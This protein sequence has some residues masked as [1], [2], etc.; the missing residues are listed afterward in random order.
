MKLKLTAVIFLGCTLF[1]SGCKKF[2]TVQP[3]DKL[4]GNAYWKSASD[5]ESFVSDIYGQFRD[6]LQSTSFMAASGELRSGQV[7]MSPE[8]DKNYR[9]YI[10]MCGQNNLLGLVAANANWN[11]NG[12]NFGSMTQWKDLY[13]VIQSANI[14]EKELSKNPI[15][16]LSGTELRQYTAEAVFIRCLT[17]LFLVRLYGDVPYYTTAY[18]STPLPRMEMVTVINNCIAELDK[19]KEDLPWTYKDPAKRAVRATKGGALVLLMYMHLWNAGFDKANKT[20]HFEKAAAYGAE[21]IQ[22]GAYKLLP[23][24]DSHLIFKG[25][26]EEGLVEIAQNFNYNETLSKY[27]PFSDMVQHYPYKRPL[28][29]HEYSFGYYRASFLHMLYPDGQTDR[30]RDTW[31]DQ[32]MFAD[33]GQFQFIKFSNVFSHGEDVN[34]DDN[35][36]IFR[37]AGALLMTAEAMVETGR[38][39]EATRLLNMVRDRAGAPKYDGPGGD[40]LRQAVYLEE[41]REL[42]GEGLFYFDLI[43]TGRVM[44]QKWCYTPLTDDQFARGGWTWPLASSVMDNNPLMTLNNYWS[45]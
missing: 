15:P 10:D 37:Y 42:M 33:N 38:G 23:I 30:R 21:L 32:S 14:L 20:T 28:S 9:A 7:K 25:R 17:Y 45:N 4:S 34:P 13:K 24:D 18:L 27:A 3:V 1:S 19:R 6:K 41:A 11:Q 8:T 26:S 12:F 16:D 22:S 40:D 5:V 44:D 29:G 43:R 39:D 2:L 35:I 31:F 36:I